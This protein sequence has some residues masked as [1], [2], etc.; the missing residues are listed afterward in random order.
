LST[1]SATS[2]KTRPAAESHTTFFRQSGWLVVATVASGMFM[3]AVQVVANRWMEPSE[4]SVFFALLR[5]FLLMGIPSAGLQIV[6]AQQTAAAVTDEHQRQ[7]AKTTHAVL[8]GTFLIWLIMAAVALAGESH[9]VAM[10]KIKNPAA[11]WATVLIGLLSLWSPMLR[12]VLQGQQNFFGLGWVMIIDGVARFASVAAIAWLG[13]Q[14]AGA[15]M[16]ALAGQ[17]VSALLAVW[18]LRRVLFA[19]GEG[20][21]WGPWLRR[22]VPLTLGIGAVQFITNADVVYSQIVFPDSD[23]I[24]THY[25]PAAMIG[26]ALV[27][28]ATPLAAVMFPKVARSA[29]LTQSTRALQLALV[30]TAL[31]CAVTALACTLL[32]ELPL[33]IIYIGKREYWAAAP[34]VPWF[35]WCLTPLILANVLV[36]NL[37]ARERFAMVP[38]LALVAAGY[39][40][41]LAMLRPRL[42]EM[43]VMTAFR[44]VIQTL[45]IFSLLLLGV[46]ALFTWRD[47]LQ[48]SRMKS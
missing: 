46:A 37:L 35:A 14:A 28:F 17:I 1:N 39:A 11:L 41:R 18:F 38:W 2:A 12:G 33:R 32:P 25:A 36:G 7:L 43:E 6:F 29:A 34:L 20:F 42:L 16:G 13:G 21:T 3:T 26:Y 27:T 24:G 48:M 45:G 47:K 8:R 31:L 4:Y 15:M 23:K 30:A 44:T 5:I 22:V 10:L 19:S 40:V 9:W